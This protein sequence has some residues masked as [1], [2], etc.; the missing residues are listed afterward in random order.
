M[1]LPIEQA[2][3]GTLNIKLKAAMVL[4]LKILPT[5]LAPTDEVIE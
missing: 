3:G 1:E 4:G 2:T 5:L